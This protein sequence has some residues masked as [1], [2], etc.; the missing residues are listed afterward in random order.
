MFLKF[1]QEADP[2]SQHLGVWSG[3][4]HSVPNGSFCLSIC[5]MGPSSRY[6]PSGTAGLVWWVSWVQ[7]LP[8]T[9]TPA[10]LVLPVT[11]SAPCH[12][13]GFSVLPLV[14]ANTGPASRSVPLLFPLPETSFSPTLP[15]VTAGAGPFHPAGLLL[16]ELP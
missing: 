9:W 12:M 4:G 8:T 10:P 6:L 15:P 11:P 14:H 16:N 2:A 5:K 1:L 3:P 7:A 13:Q